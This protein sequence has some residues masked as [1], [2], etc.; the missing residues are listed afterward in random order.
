MAPKIIQM[1]SDDLGMMN[2]DV[3][4][5]ILTAPH[6]Y[7]T[8]LIPKRQKGQYREISQPASEIKIIQRYLVSSVLNELPV[9]ESVVSYRRGVGI[10]ENASRH[11]YNTYI[12]KLDF[13]NFFPS[14]S[15]AD[16]Q[17]HLRKYLG[18]GFS[19]EDVKI[20]ARLVSRKN[21]STGRLAL[22]IGAPSSPAIS[23]S[24]L[25]DFDT[26]VSEPLKTEGIVYTRYAD[27]LTFSTNKKEVL[28][29]IP[30]LIQQVIESLDYPS[31]ELKHEKTIHLSKRNRRM[32]TGLILT[33][34]GDVSIGRDRKRLIRTMID[35]YRKGRLDAD[36]AGQLQGLLAFASDVEP[37]FVDR[38]RSKYGKDLITSLLRYESQA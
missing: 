13:K 32:V 7:K 19:D 10:A 8:Y 34:E 4:R 33:P 36:K 22:S 17:G 18:E 6:R 31:L 16:I 29:K 28:G 38:M 27:D 1:I 21:N 37:D 20:I 5:L 23:N 2:H 3:R 30:S 25:Y 9:H 14:I 12:L 26:R 35:Y 15:I 11:C 24:I